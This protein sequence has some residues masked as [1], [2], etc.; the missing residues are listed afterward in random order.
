M[1]KTLRQENETIVQLKGI[2]AD[3]HIPK[4]LLLEG[5]KALEQELTN[6]NEFFSKAKQMD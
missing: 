6:K 1:L 5:K 2:C 4:G 3:K